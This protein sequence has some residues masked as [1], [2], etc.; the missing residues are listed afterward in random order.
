MRARH[1]GE[2]PER[3]RIDAATLDRMGVTDLV[4]RYDAWVRKGNPRDIDRFLATLKREGVLSLR[5]LCEVHSARPVQP[6]RAKPKLPSREPLERRYELLAELGQGGMGTVLLAR[7]KLLLRTVA[8]K[9]LRHGAHEALTARFVGEACITAQLDHP[10]IISVHALERTRDDQPAFTMKVING[11]TLGEIIWDARQKAR[12]RK[13]MEPA[14]TL[15]GRLEIF[16]KVCEGIA[17]AHERGVL[18]RDIKPENL[19]V[20]A[21]GEVTI[22]DWGIAEILRKVEGT[23]E[24]TTVVRASEAGRAVGTPQYM[25]PEQARGL[26]LT[27]LS[28]QYALGLVLQEIVTFER[29]ITTDAPAEA[30]L[31]AAAAERRPLRNA[32]GRRVPKD[33][34]AIIH[35]AC[36]QSP[37]R[38]YPDVLSLADDVRRYLQQREIKARPD[39]LL[40]AM[41]RWGSRHT[42]LLAS[43]VVGALLAAA[44]ILLMAVAS[45]S[46]TMAWAASEHARV[47][48]LTASVVSHSH[49]IDVEFLRVEAALEQL[50]GSTEQLW[51]FAR[52]QPVPIYRRSD[53]RGDEPP[54]DYL[55]AETYGR[56]MSFSDPLVLVPPGVVYEGP[57]EEEIGRLA[58]LRRVFR[59]AM[60]ASYGADGIGLSPE[61]QEALLRGRTTSVR[62]LYVGLESGPLINY[63]GFPD[64][65]DDYDPRKRPWYRSTRKT[66][67]A[68]WGEL[69]PD[70]SGLSIL[71]PSNRALYAADGTFIGVAGADMSLDTVV[72]LLDMPSARDAW[73]LD[74]RGHIIVST[75]DRGKRMDAG[76]H[77]NLSLGTRPFEVEGV[78]QGIVDGEETGLLSVSRELFVWSRLTSVPWTYVVALEPGA[79]P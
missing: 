60:L 24:M 73:L 74:E 34:A 36:A 65:S 19:M 62:W 50:A 59:S 61:R 56:K 7:D 58:P 39:N 68:R 76:L 51:S 28:D 45:V 22:M 6:G 66:R 46:G 20:G 15:E 35:K 25:A 37:A 75:E 47:A 57:I 71:L 32:N 17:Y 70:D 12:Q 14:E 69:Y 29:A 18:H 44:F 54:V 52:P 16:V 72:A 26:P 49:Q 30:L 43:L 8:V 2:L 79:Q 4:E 11:R 23:S 41:R 63:P 42:G 27:P 31:R 3:L 77:D 67:G 78:V 21:F 40:R 5:Q 48:G 13:P 53:Y 10:N 38:R 55:M 1:Q 64:L 9:V 33:L